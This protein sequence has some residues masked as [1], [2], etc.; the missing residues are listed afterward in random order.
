MKYGLE[1]P[2][3]NYQKRR[4]YEAIYNIPYTA[5]HTAVANAIEKLLTEG[6]TKAKE[7][8][9]P[10]YLLVQSFVRKQLTSVHIA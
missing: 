2:G 10:Q 4:E 7:F 3:T 6:L 1:S 9:S 5:D 8:L